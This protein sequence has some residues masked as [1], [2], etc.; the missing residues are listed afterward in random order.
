MVQMW[1]D[2]QKLNLLMAEH[3]ITIKALCMKS[4]IHQS[5]MSR[6]INGKNKP[7]PVTF[8]KIA[9]ALNVPVIAI[10][11]FTRLDKVDSHSIVP[12]NKEVLRY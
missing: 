7:R 5:M 1:I 11:D 10:V 12:Q 8:G 2:N 3:G 4:G 9:K 6:L